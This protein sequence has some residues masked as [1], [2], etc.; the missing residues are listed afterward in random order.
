MEQE[1]ERA[2]DRPASLGEAMQNDVPFDI[3]YARE[4][5]RHEQSLPVGILAGSGAALLGALGWALITALTHFQIGFMAV[6]VGF[7]VGTA[8]RRYGK[9]FDPVFGIA[10]AV[11]SLAGCALGNLLA[12]CAMAAA[13]NDMSFFTLLGRLDPVIAARLM[14]ASFQPMDLLFYGIAVYEGYRLS[15]RRLTQA[16]IDTLQTR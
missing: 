6:G 1:P 4:Q 7:L 8:M 2:V 16:D 5:L 13:A 15:L 14:A 9:G 10:G 3:A 12:V 11:L